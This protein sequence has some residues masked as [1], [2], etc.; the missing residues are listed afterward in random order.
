MNLSVYMIRSMA[1]RATVET[2][3]SRNRLLLYF[4]HRRIPLVVL[5][6]PPEADGLLKRSA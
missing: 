5:A 1:D 2:S 6:D 3:G 4:V